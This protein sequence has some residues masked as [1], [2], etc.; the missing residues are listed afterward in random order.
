M[1]GTKSRE[2]CR[3]LGVELA[4]VVPSAYPYP[5]TEQAFRDIE[6]DFRKEISQC[7]PKLSKL[8]DQAFSDCKRAHQGHHRRA[9]RVPY[10]YHSI[11]VAHLLMRSASIYDKDILIA[12]LLHDACEADST[13]EQH[14]LTQDKIYDKYGNRVAELVSK[15]SCDIPDGPDKN[16]KY[17]E[18]I[19]N[20]ANDPDAFAIKIAD[21][22]QNTGSLSFSYGAGF[23]EQAISSAQKYLGALEIF[24]KHMPSTRLA[25]ENFLYQELQSM[26]AVLAKMATREAN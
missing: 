18:H 24:L 2:N 14:R 1:E 12:A 26:Q 10:A 6:A 23:K 15:L 25:S 7:D 21:F 13:N 11:S 17:A 8:V 20:L 19:A 3:S 9:P 5:D 4:K 16:T 22:L